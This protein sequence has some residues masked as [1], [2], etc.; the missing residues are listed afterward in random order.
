M[1][2]VHSVMSTENHTLDGGFGR[3][4][5]LAAGGTGR[6]A[7]Q[8]C[9][10]ASKWIGT[11]ESGGAGKR[12]EREGGGPATTL[13]FEEGRRWRKGRGNVI[14]YHFY[15]GRCFKRDLCSGSY[16]FVTLRLG[17]QQFHHVVGRGSPPPPSTLDRPRE[18]TSLPP[19]PRL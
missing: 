15:R 7:S 2:I 10:Q 16:T 12:R 14:F 17:T 6:A 18:M 1:N 8:Q 11:R 19:P 3:E 4:C 13:E 9:K 5:C